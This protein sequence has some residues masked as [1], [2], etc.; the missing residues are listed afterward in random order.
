[1]ALQAVLHLFETLKA[2]DSKSLDEVT[3]QIERLIEIIGDIDVAEVK[4][5]HI[6]D[7]VTV[8]SADF[9]PDDYSDK[10]IIQLNY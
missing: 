1:M 3:L 5:S 9:K 10:V 6:A 7:Y 8:P 4:R 2:K